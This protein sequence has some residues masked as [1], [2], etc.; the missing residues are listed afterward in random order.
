[1]SRPSSRRAT[2]STCAMW[3]SSSGPGPTIL[4]RRTRVR[5]PL[6]TPRGLL[7]WG[8]RS[9]SHCV[10]TCPPQGNDFAR[11]F[12]WRKRS[13]R[14]ARRRRKARRLIRKRRRSFPRAKQL[15]AD[16][17]PGEDKFDHGP[18]TRDPRLAPS[19]VDPAP[20]LRIL[21][22]DVQ[23]VPRVPTSRR[24]ALDACL[25]STLAM[26]RLHH[27]RRA[28]TAWTPDRLDTS[29][30]E[31]SIPSPRTRTRM[32]ECMELADSAA[33]EAVVLRDVEVRPLSRARLTN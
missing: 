6:P 20:R 12:R 16:V 17:A 1:M 8:A 30:A 19:L 27:G 3:V 33:S 25:R 32:L 24:A 5:F 10:S 28:V 18:K 15:V 9:F 31:G 26:V 13:R 23:F 2:V 7:A 4:D 21:V 29:I 14:A 22:A 11:L